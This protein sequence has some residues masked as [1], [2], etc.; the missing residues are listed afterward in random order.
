MEARQDYK[1]AESTGDV[2][3]LLKIIQAEALGHKDLI[4]PALSIANGMRR[5]WLMRQD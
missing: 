5:L 2:V 4:H 3:G 1:T